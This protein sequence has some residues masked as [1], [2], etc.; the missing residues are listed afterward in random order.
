MLLDGN[1][2]CNFERLLHEHVDRLVHELWKFDFVELVD[3]NAVIVSDQFSD[4]FFN[5]YY[6][7]ASIRIEPVDGYPSILKVR[8]RVVVGESLQ[9]RIATFYSVDIE[10]TVAITRCN[11]RDLCFYT[12]CACVEVGR[13]VRVGFAHEF[14]DA[15]AELECG[16]V[17][18]PAPVDVGFFDPDGHLHGF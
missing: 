14:V 9:E 7:L 13:S 3:V 18:N 16:C 15:V 11:E 2:V 1:C 6:D 12:V 17:E 4:G 8:E 5:E 10:L